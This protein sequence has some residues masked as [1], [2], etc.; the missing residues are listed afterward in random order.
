MR[1]KIVKELSEKYP[2]S[3][4]DIGELYD[5]VVKKHELFPEFSIPEQCEIIIKNSI[6]HASNMVTEFYKHT[7]EV[8][9]LKRTP[10]QSRFIELMELALDVTKAV[11][12]F[13]NV[14]KESKPKPPIPPEPRTIATYGKETFFTKWKV[15]KEYLLN[16]F[17]QK[18]KA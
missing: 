5:L 8:K 13:Q 9:K 7:F 6:Q 17:N 2:L 15:S 11:I 3:R 4:E 10:E 14:A 1:N 18:K 12:D 16:I